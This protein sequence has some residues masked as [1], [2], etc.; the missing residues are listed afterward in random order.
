MSLSTL[1]NNQEKIKERREREDG[2]NYMQYPIHI[3][4]RGHKQTN[5]QAV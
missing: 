2:D 3:L 5:L 4:E 1:Q